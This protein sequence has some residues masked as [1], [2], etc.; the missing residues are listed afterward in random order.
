MKIFAFIFARGNSK[1]LKNKN[2]KNFLGKPLLVRTINFAKKSKIFDKII[3]STDSKRILNIGKKNNLF[4]IKRPKK[5]ATDNSPEW[6]SWKHGVKFLHRRNYFFDLMVVL[7][8]TAPI[9]AI[10]DLKKCIKA[11]SSNVD[12]VT[13]ISRSN[14]HP[15]FNMVRRDKKYYI[16]IYNKSKKPF[17]RR[18]DTEEIYNLSNSMYVTKPDFVLA[19]QNMFL[20][21]IKGIEVPPER[22]IDIDN[23]SDFFF[24]EYTFNRLKK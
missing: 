21:K 4:L 23:L 3:L 17:F 5:L 6:L 18:Q 7:P 10:N 1:G 14:H 22:A 15:A 2:I 12:L 9:R 16:S 13:T 20:G 11:L 8:C 19:K 24:A